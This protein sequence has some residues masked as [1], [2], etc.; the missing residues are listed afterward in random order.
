MI[1]IAVEQF[2]AWVADGLD[3]IPDQL[4]ANMEYIAVMVDNTRPPGRLFELYEG[5]PR[6]RR[7]KRC[8][9]GNGNSREG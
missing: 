6:T 9:E 1:T 7:G 5:A 2:E 8:R 4:G 3:G